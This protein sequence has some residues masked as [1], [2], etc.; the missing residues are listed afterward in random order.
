MEYKID[1][2]SIHRLENRNKENKNIIKN[3]KF[4]RTLNRIQSGKGIFV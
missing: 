3:K 4:K 2:F 1:K